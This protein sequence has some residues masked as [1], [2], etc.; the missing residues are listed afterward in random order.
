M[1][2]RALTPRAKLGFLGL[3]FLGSTQPMAQ[4]T[5]G[6][7]PDLPGD[8]LVRCLQSGASLVTECFWTLGGK[9]GFL[10]LGFLGLT[11]SQVPSTSGPKPGLNPGDLLVGCR[12]SKVSL[13]TDCAWTPGAK[14]V[15]Q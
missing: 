15:F 12:Q 10:G 9:L 3:E 14:L 8:S 13:V 5:E 7:K 2:D 1:I 11:Q 6:A 4:G